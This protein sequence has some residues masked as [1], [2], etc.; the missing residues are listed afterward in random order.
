MLNR[1]DALKSIFWDSSNVAKIEQI[2]EL[3][4]YTKNGKWIGVTKKKSELLAAY[5]YLSENYFLK[6]GPKT[7]QARLLYEHFGLVTGD[8]GYVSERTLRNTPST[9]DIEEFKSV[10]M[11]LK[12]IN[13]TSST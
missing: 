10:F 13:P 1:Y 12:P 11:R 8:G 6:S 5:Q 3:R 4:E 7:S 2:F 9:K